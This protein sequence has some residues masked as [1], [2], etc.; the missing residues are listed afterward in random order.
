M[1]ANT[2]GVKNS[3]SIK[4]LVEEAW[5]M[6]HPMT[7][8]AAAAMSDGGSGTVAPPRIAAEDVEPDVA[9]VADVE[10]FAP[11]LAAASL[12]F[13]AVYGR[14]VDRLLRCGV[15]VVVVVVII[16]R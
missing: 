1:F 3:C 11:S 9:N 7:A 16:P 8:A 5:G 12:T 2:K 10:A 4:Y 14:V 15:V 6:G 13:I